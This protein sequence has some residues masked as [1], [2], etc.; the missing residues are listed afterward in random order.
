MNCQQLHL[1]NDVMEKI[2]Y[3]DVI[4]DFILKNAG[5]KIIFT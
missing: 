2:K 4:E 3:K 1:K 5:R